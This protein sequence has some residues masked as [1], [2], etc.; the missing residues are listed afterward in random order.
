MNAIKLLS[1]AIRL[2][3]PKLIRQGLTA[4]GGA[5]AG[6]GVIATDQHA[7]VPMIITGLMLWAFTALHSA[8]VKSPP[9]AELVVVAKKIIEA[10]IAQGFSFYSGWLA[11]AGF[12]GDPADAEAVALFAANL[13]LS[14]LS[15]PADKHKLAQNSAR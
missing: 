9:S 4:L 11:T 3:L 1:P 15:R 7:S 8:W 2:L 13:G 5:L 6:A 10:L 14:A 12:N